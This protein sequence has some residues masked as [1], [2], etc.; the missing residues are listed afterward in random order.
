[1]AER[2]R[3]LARLLGINERLEELWRRAQEDGLLNRDE[4]DEIERLRR[5]RDEIEGTRLGAIWDEIER[6]Q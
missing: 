6:S 1:M 5:E 4:A 2:D 3:E